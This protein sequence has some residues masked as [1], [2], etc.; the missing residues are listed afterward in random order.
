MS[1]R[2]LRF[3]KQLAV[4]TGGA[5]GIG[6]A[7]AITFTHFGARIALLDINKQGVEQVA[8]ECNGKVTSCKPYSVDVADFEEMRRVFSQINTDLGQID[9]LVNVAGIWEYAPFLEMTN[10]SLDRMMEVNFKGCL[11][12][13]KLV[14]PQMVQRRCG[15]IVSVSSITGKVGSSRCMAHYSAS[16]GALIALTRSLA[17]EFGE[18]GININAV[19]PGLIE[20]PMAQKIS[21]AVREDTQIPPNALRRNG[22]PEEV[23]AVIAFL[24][25]SLS[26]FVTG[27]AWN[28]CGGTLFD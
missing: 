27:Q 28:V 11:N 5:S 9:I 2:Q 19:T 10:G 20:T 21:E 25:S 22:K 16:K 7:T 8:R 3:N 14:L 24:S 17:R 12:A 13:I 1:T 23:A 15:K 18:F 26:S 6:N 4:I